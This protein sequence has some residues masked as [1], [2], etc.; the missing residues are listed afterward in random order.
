MKKL[1]API[2]VFAIA[3]LWGCSEKKEVSFNSDLSYEKVKSAGVLV[4]GHMGAF[5]PMGFYDK[6]SNVVGFDIDVAT[7]VCAR[8][9]VKLKPQLISWKIKENELNFGN[10]DCIWN[11]MS[12][13]SARAA[14]MNLSDPYLMNRLVF[15]VKDKSI[16]HLDALKGK[17]IAV[18]KASTSEPV[19]MNSELG[20]VVEVNAYES[21]ELAIEALVAGNVDAVFMDE[22]FAKYW[23]VTHGTN[24]PI[25]DEGKYKEVYAIGFRKQDQALRDSVN[26]ALA[27]MKNDGKFAAISAKWFGK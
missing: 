17:K 14:S 22:V 9:G 25:L 10:V 27:S 23:N 15:M 7:E 18:Q 21:M 2:A 11:G 16:E 6:D 5:P 24:Y 13:D 20:K 1:F 3:L 4:L 8:M 19:L 26:A 12:V